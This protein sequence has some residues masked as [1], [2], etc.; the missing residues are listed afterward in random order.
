MFFSEDVRLMR[1]SQVASSSERAS[2]SIS[3]ALS[4]LQ[5]AAVPPHLQPSKFD[6]Q[7]ACH[8]VSTC[9]TG[10]VSKVSYPASIDNAQRIPV[11]C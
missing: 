11:C 2:K 6:M 8:A 9:L 5:A 4:V 1:S 7:L 10:W 3:P